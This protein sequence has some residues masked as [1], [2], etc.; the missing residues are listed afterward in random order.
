M[1]IVDSSVVSQNDIQNN[2]FLKPDNAGHSKA[3]STAALL[4]ELND[5]VATSFVQKVAIDCRF[6][7]T[8]L[9]NFYR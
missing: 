6:A 7:W 1:T 9:A 8:Q 5:D 3:C 4:K 2:F